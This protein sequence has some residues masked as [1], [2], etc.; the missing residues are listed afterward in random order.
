MTAIQIKGDRMMNFGRGSR[1]NSGFA[2]YQAIMIKHHASKLISVISRKAFILST[3][4]KDSK[5]R[6]DRAK[7]IP[8]K[9]MSAFRIKGRQDAI[10]S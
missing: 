1:R 6:K 5:N 9:I 3:L 8:A 10:M 7:N 4:S 2:R